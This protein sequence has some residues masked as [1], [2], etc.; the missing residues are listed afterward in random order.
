MTFA[1]YSPYKTW[2][3]GN[4]PCVPTVNVE[5]SAYS[6]LEDGAIL[7][8]HSLASDGEVDFV[9]DTLI[10]ELESVRKSAKKELKSIN[11]KMRD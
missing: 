6:P 2:K 1:L 11:E 5:V 4:L 3:K 9:I 10:K 7:I 8:G